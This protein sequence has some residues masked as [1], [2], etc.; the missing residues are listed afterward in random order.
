MKLMVEL[1]GFLILIDNKSVL[2]LGDKQILLFEEMFHIYQHAQK[3]PYK[4]T[5][6]GGDGC[7]MMLKASFLWLEF[8][9]NYKTLF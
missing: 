8:D 4:I 9:I 3:T 2:S 7:G 6:L 5:Y 1:I